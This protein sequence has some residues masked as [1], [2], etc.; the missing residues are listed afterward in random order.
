MIR[1]DEL[2]GNM[3]WLGL[4]VLAVFALTISVQSSNDA[5][6][7][8]S[9]DPL[10]GNSF[11]N[12]TQSLNSLEG[13]GIT[14]YDQFTGETPEAG[15]GSIVLFGI[16]GFGKIIGNGIISLFWIILKFP[17]VLLG[18]PVTVV[19]V[20]IAWLIVIFIVGAWMLYKLGG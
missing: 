19:S 15:F 17:L 18:I 4:F 10:V 13:T 11:S 12:L 9:E 20:S 5:V 6:Q 8:I 2:V 16:V 7:P 3:L 1:F 14:Q